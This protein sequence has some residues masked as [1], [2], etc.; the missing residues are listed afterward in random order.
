MCTV[1]EFLFLIGCFE[2][3]DIF[4]DFNSGLIGSFIYDKY[5]QNYKFT[6]VSSGSSGVDLSVNAIQSE[7][8]NFYMTSFCIVLQSPCLSN[9]IES[10]NAPDS[11][12]YCGNWLNQCISQSLL[13]LNISFILSAH[14]KSTLITFILCNHVI[15]LVFVT[16]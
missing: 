12:H 7:V 16:F 1:L 10:G 14:Q 15:Y 11:I 2:D 5:S 4:C 8:S 6:G 13:S 3:M 9:I